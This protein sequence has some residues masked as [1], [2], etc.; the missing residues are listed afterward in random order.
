MRKEQRMVK[1]HKVQIID[2]G[3]YQLAMVIINAWEDIYTAD[4]RGI[5]PEAVESSVINL[6]ANTKANIDIPELYITVL[7]WKK[8]GERWTDQELVPVRKYSYDPKT[9]SL[10]VQ[11]R[12]LPGLPRF[13][14]VF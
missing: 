6:R 12:D 10:K 3:V 14:H 2:N 5:H 7:L 4:A 9:G 1:G 13:Y 8:S 11:M